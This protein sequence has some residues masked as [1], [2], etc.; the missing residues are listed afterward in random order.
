M[1]IMDLLYYD[2]TD[3]EKGNENFRV[4]NLKEFTPK[5]Y[6]KPAGDILVTIFRHIEELERSNQQASEN[7]LLHLFEDVPAHV[8]IL[9]TSRELQKILPTLLSRMI[10]LTPEQQKKG[11]NPHNNAIES[12]LNGDPTPIFQMTL[13]SGEESQFTREDAL[14]IVS[15]LQQAIEYGT[16]SP[17]HAQKLHK[18]LL[19]LETTNTSAKYL[20]D[21]LIISLSCE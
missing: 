13:K 20:I 7:A 5:L 9:V 14:W 10:L 1:G 2:C 12:Y 8:L 15:G 17:R 19:Q 11:E 3:G 16:L 18:T 6:E 21:Q 4:K